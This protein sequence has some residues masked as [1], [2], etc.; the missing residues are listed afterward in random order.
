MKNTDKKTRARWVFLG[1]IYSNK[2]FNK[3]VLMIK[4]NDI[5]KE[6][7]DKNSKFKLITKNE[8]GIRY[9]FLYYCLNSITFCL[10][11]IIYFLVLITTSRPAL[12]GVKE[13]KQ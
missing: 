5:F 11:V 10:L 4:L 13:K 9:I 12:S 6:L 1:K 7:V 2:E 8:K 3:K